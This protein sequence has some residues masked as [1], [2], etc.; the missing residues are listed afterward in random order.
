MTKPGRAPWGSTE[1]D[2]T[3]LKQVERVVEQACGTPDY[4]V[5]GEAPGRTFSFAA[6]VAIGPNCCVQSYP[7]H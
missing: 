1:I 7:L 6:A 5:H 4:Q 2:A 3:E